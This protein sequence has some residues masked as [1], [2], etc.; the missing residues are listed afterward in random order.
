MNIILN[1]RKY[2]LKITQK[3]FAKFLLDKGCG[4]VKK[5]AEYKRIILPYRK[6]DVCRWENGQN[7]PGREVRQALAQILG[8]TEKEV[9]EAIFA[10]LQGLKGK[11]KKYNIDTNQ[12][13]ML[14]EI[15]L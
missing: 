10:N 6:S 15:A 1:L 13:E 4:R 8:K 9:Y 12:Y 3:E 14:T 2:Q 7:M 5:I 11:I